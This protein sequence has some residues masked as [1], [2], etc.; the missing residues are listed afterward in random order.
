MGAKVNKSHPDFPEYLEKCKALRDKYLKLIE[1]EEA[2]YP[3]WNLKSKIRNPA[4]LATRELI[5][6]HDNELIALQK[7]YNYLFTE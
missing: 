3:E 4:E 5:K 1:K 7:E 6:R 2:K